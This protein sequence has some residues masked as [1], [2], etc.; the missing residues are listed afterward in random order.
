[1]GAALDLD[2]VIV[3][4]ISHGGD[5][6]PTVGRPYGAAE[7]DS[8]R[9]PTFWSDMLTARSPWLTM[10]TTWVPSITGSRR[11]L[12]CFIV[13]SA[14]SSESSAPIVTTSLRSITSDTL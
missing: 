5:S 6:T 4:L 8:T 7:M 10:P 9:S 14:S 2:F 1:E 3:L 12:Y 13:R 11:T